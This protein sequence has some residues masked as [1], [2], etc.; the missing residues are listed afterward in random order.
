[1]VRSPSGARPRSSVTARDWTFM[2]GADRSGLAA[3]GGGGVFYAA[4]ERDL[5]LNGTVQSTA[6]TLFSGGSTHLNSFVST[7]AVSITT[8]ADLFF[9]EGANIQASGAIV[10]KVGR[11][12]I[13][14]G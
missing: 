1:M 4:A 13:G 11:D 2:P 14:N 8:G 10:L 7:G 5:F 3:L 9:D 12:L 6:L